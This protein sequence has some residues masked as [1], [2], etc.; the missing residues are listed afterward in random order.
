M[1]FLTVVMLALGGAACASGV[2]KGNAD[3]N[4]VEKTVWNPYAES[5]VEVK[6]SRP[7]QSGAPGPEIYRGGSKEGDDARMLEDGFDMLG[8]SSFEAGD[9]SPD[10]LTNHAEKVKADRVLVYTRLRGKSPASM[11]L[12]QLREK[13]LK[14]EGVHPQGS[15]DTAQQAIYSYYASYWIRLPPPI[16]G[17]HVK[18]GNAGG[19]V[20]LAVIKESP[21]ARAGIIRGD[22]L[23]SIGDMKMS[24]P[25]ALAQAAEQFQGQTVDVVFLRNSVPHRQSITL[26]H[27]HI[28]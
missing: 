12:Q 13:K 25:E 18:G 4:G 7:V 20:V 15:T 21:A 22:I 23:S 9:V 6:S 26:S 19:L 28:Q 27:H 11:K 10:L 17:L 16:V 8:Y 1:R 24:G 3:P 5:Y 14:K 2:V